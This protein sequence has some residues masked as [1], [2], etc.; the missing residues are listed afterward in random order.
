MNGKALHFREIVN[1]EFPR[2][3]ENAHNNPAHPKVI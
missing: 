2:A 1:N 3:I